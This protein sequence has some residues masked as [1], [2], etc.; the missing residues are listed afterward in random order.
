MSLEL[1]N[2]FENELQQNYS[3]INQ[4]YIEEKKPFIS[5]T[6]SKKIISG[7]INIDCQKDIEIIYPETNKPFRNSEEA[8]SD[9]CNTE[10]TKFLPSMSAQ[11]GS[12][13]DLEFAPKLK[14]FRLE[15]EM[16]MVTP[17]NVGAKSTIKILNPA[18]H[19]LSQSKL[20]NNQVESLVDLGL[21][22]TPYSRNMKTFKSTRQS[23]CNQL[24]KKGSELTQRL[25][26]QMVNIE[27]LK[28][29]T[30]QMSC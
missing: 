28:H 3:K 25:S 16:Y 9:L 6:P 23:T 15:T 18:E 7:A 24:T 8:N 14:P 20:K 22:L 11:S 30:S 19:F 29:I 27:K 12:N 10:E 4:L 5:H 17:M 1:L 2:Q 13:M 21:Q 26:R